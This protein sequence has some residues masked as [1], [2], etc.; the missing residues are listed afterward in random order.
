METKFNGG[1]WIKGRSRLLHLLSR[2][3]FQFSLI[4]ET[5]RPF[6]TEIRKINQRVNAI[7]AAI[8]VDKYVSNLL[9]FTCRPIII[10]QQLE[11]VDKPFDL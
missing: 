8:P 4:A 7:L 2:V 6:W 5:H 10:I 3:K 9:N 1:Q 11:S